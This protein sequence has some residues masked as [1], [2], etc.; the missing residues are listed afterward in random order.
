[1]KGSLPVRYLLSHQAGLAA[2]SES[3]P[4]GA[5]FDWDVMTAALARQK[6]WWEPGTQFGYHGV[7]YGWLVGEVIRR[8]SGKSVGAYFRDEIGDPLGLDFFIGLPASE[9][10]RCAEVIPAGPTRVVP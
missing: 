5:A 6:P 10:A 3:L 4:P 9:D 1:G 2:A 7:T 8:V